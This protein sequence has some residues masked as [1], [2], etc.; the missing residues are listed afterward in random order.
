[1][2]IK[3]DF[4]VYISSKKSFVYVEDSCSLFPFHMKQELYVYAFLVGAESREIMWSGFCCIHQQ[5]F[6][7]CD[8]KQDNDRCEKLC[9]HGCSRHNKG[10]G[11]QAVPTGSV[12]SCYC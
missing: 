11:C 1:M 3:S 7:A 4:R 6:G 9:L 8:T 12:C 10:G 2:Q 5:Q